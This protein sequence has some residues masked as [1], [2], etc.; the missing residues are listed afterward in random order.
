MKA[1]RASGP[2]PFSAPH[3]CLPV[4]LPDFQGLWDELLDS[5]ITS[6]ILFFTGRALHRAVGMVST[7]STR[8]HRLFLPTPPSWSSSSQQKSFVWKALHCVFAV[9]QFRIVRSW[10]EMLPRRGTKTGRPPLVRQLLRLSET[11]GSLPFLETTPMSI[12]AICRCSLYARHG[13]AFSYLIFTSS[14]WRVT[15]FCFSFDT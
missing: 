6:V 15:G 5:P 4:R 10:T 11:Q 9:V 14:G 13:A 7:K 8:N 3:P 12:A 2:W 1:R